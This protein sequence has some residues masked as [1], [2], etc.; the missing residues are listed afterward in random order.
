MCKRFV[1]LLKYGDMDGMGGLNTGHTAWEDF[2]LL[3]ILNEGDC[4]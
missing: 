2:A 4:T 1:N 3:F